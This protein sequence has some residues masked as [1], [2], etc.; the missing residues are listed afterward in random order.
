RARHDFAQRARLG[1]QGAKTVPGRLR[2]LEGFAMR[3]V[4]MK[5]V[6]EIGT[7]LPR[8]RAAA[9]P[10]QPFRR[11]ALDFSLCSVPFHIA[12]HTTS[13]RP[14]YPSPERGGR[15]GEADR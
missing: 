13:L 14:V 3:G 11:P 1:P 15:V 8:Q 12:V 2:L 5:P 10:R 7:F 4:G 6:L 9:E